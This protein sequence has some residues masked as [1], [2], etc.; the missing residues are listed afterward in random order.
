M[1]DFVDACG[2]A[3]LHCLHPRVLLVSLLPLA[4]V[5]AMVFGLGWLYWE[6]SVAGVRATLERSQPLA[7]AFEWLDSIGAAAVRA[8]FAPL[9][10]V[11]LAVPAVVLATLLLVAWLA[12][13][14][15]A[16][17][18]A[19]ER[20]AGLEASADAPGA[21]RNVGWS[22]ACTAAALLALLVSLPLWFVPPLVLVLPPWLW[23]WLA[24][25]VLAY[26]A[27]ARHADIDERHA[28]LH[29]RRWPLRTIGFVCGV[30]GMLPSLLWAA[31]AALLG[32]ATPLMLAAVWLYTLIFVFASLWF[33]HYLLA[34]LAALRG[35]R[36]GLPD[37][38]RSTS[39]ATA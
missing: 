12:A 3:V 35:A 1:S 14:A 34:A 15:L 30:V 20:F 29:E 6:P 7:L 4:V 11:A 23:G 37:G 19:R 22:L 27:L 36:A 31:G 28:L 16:G 33:A 24:Y 38:Q 32:P 17:F 13:P 39:S 25:R 5:L 18:V 21:W 10:L 2:R 26:A 8:M 9:V